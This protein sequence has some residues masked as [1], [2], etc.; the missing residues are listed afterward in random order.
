MDNS[1]VQLQAESIE[2]R[3]FVIRNQQVMIDRDLAQLY[4]IE[5]KVLNQAVKRN[6]ERF[7]ERFMFQLTKIE[8][9]HYVLLRSQNAI[10]R[11]QTVTLNDTGESPLWSQIV[12][13]NDLK[14]QNATSNLRGKHSKYLSYAFTEQGVAMLSSVLRNETAVQ[15]SIR[16][17][18]AFVAMRRFLQNNAQI[19]VELGSIKQHLIESDLHHKEN[20][21]KIE[22]LFT[23]MDK[24]KV[25]DKQGI[26]FQGQI[27]DAYAKF[28]SFIQQA[29]KEI[30][31]IDQYVDLSV[32]ER[33]KKKRKGVNVTIFTKTHTQ[34][35]AQDIQQYNA[36]YPT[37]SVQHTTK[38][39]DRFLII[40]NSIIYHIGA[41]LKD[42]GKKCFAFEILEDASTLI[43]A[44]LANV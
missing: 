42:L 38:M 7:P 11:S 18:D 24:Y 10:S 27:F 43:P 32:L 21:Q 16:I 34:L 1:I 23:L 6:I 28:E 19:F 35:T 9:E 26:F 17:M 8:Q 44:I 5:T 2:N 14:S 12:T 3:I 25:E 37:L 41:S 15:V 33:L 39:H 31:L 29:K 30:I 22:R 4:G 20:D 13:L 40:D 36:Q